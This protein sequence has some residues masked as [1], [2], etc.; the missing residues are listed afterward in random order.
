LRGGSSLMGPARTICSRGHGMQAMVRIC[1]WALMQGCCQIQPST[2]TVATSWTS[3][4]ERRG[5]R[6]RA[7]CC[8]ALP[9]C[10]GS[11]WQCRWGQW[12]PSWCVCVYL[13]RQK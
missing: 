8:C 5:G 4:G 11:M 13:G 1:G 12:W 7:G 6:W 9:E 3:P 2:A 10:C